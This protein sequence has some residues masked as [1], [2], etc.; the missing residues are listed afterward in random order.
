[1]FFTIAKKLH[2]AYNQWA[3][4][5]TPDKTTVET[6]D[7]TE[8]R[9]V[10]SPDYVEC[11]P[12]NP[13][14]GLSIDELILP[15]VTILGTWPIVNEKHVVVR[16]DVNQKWIWYEDQYF[17]SLQ[18]SVMPMSQQQWTFERFTD[19]VNRLIKAGADI[20]VVDTFGNNLLDLIYMYGAYLDIHD[21]HA[22]YDY[23]VS[24]GVQPRN[25]P[26]H[27]I[28]TFIKYKLDDADH[29][30]QRVFTNPRN[31]NIWHFEVYRQ[32]VYTS[33]DYRYY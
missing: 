1:M 3:Y 10:D 22:M 8:V 2:E 33:S 5:E 13:P 18:A 15:P 23:L 30:W 4:P 28:C 12:T 29:H 24:K 20:H 7:I 21:K 11:L 31:V 25:S 14:G 19:E 17:S 16:G 26:I 27:M 32:N 6:T 9:I